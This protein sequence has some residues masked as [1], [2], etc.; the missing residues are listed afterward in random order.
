MKTSNGQ[1]IC[2]NCKETCDGVDMT[3]DFHRCKVCDNLRKKD[4]YRTKREERLAYAKDYY[5]KKKVEAWR[6]IG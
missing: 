6:G 5:H 1:Y 3:K 2:P 4:Y